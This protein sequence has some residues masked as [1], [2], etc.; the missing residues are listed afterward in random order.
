M[1]QDSLA[2]TLRGGVQ[3]PPGGSRY[4]P[5]GPGTPRG[6]PGTPGGGG[7]SGSP[8]GGDT[9]L[10]L[11]PPPPPCGQTNTCENSTFPSYYVRGR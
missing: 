11:I 3:V 6:G 9:Q 7:G 2:L 8:P 1:Q 5:G 10:D 4:P